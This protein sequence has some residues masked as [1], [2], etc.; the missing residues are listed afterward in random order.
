MAYFDNFNQAEEHGQAATSLLQAHGIPVTP[1]NYEVSYCYVSGTKPELKAKIDALLAT[2]TD[3]TTNSM[4]D[5]YAR[6]CAQDTSSDT[7]DRATASVEE[8]ITKVLGLIDSSASDTQAYSENLK[9]YG[10]SLDGPD[11]GAELKKVL[12]A[13][14]ND[15]KKM[16][17]KT[18]A[19]NSELTASSEQISQLRADLEDVTRESRTDPLT[20]LSN[21]GV[22]DEQIDG[23]RSRRR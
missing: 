5:L 23:P 12:A 6:F 22:F 17:A 2:G 19:L 20:K 3:L 7:L 11:A 4:A 16:Q 18:Q 14:L 1:N 21:R 10:K 13:V 8:Q 9:S 15:T